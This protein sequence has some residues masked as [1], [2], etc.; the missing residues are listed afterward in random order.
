M[1]SVCLTVEDPP[2]QTGFVADVWIA[3]RDGLECVASLRGRP[4]SLVGSITGNNHNCL[5]I[6]RM[7]HGAPDRS[8]TCDL[9]LSRPDPRNLRNNLQRETP[10]FHWPGSPLAAATRVGC[11]PPLWQE[12]GAF[13]AAYGLH[14]YLS[15]LPCPATAGTSSPKYSYRKTLLPPGPVRHEVTSGP[16][17]VYRSGV[18]S[19]SVNSST[20]CAAIVDS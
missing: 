5:F 20:P 2:A 4:Q 16:E 6:I 13:W 7:C 12:C 3:F 14:P 11:C 9:P 19:K 17:S 10:V 15:P 8:R 18:T 1:Q